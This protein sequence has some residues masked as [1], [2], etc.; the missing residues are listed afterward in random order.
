M[1][2]EMQHSFKH[3]M[4]E[5]KARVGDH[6]LLRKRLAALGAEHVG[7]FHQ[8]DLYFKVPEG[9]LKL[10][11][12]KGTSTVELIYY[13]RENIAGPKSDD[14]FILR[15]KEPGE[16]K[17]ILK[18]TLTPLIVVDKARDIYR[19]NGIQI[20][21]DTVEK[22]GKFIEFEKQTEN[23]PETTEKDRLALQKLMEKLEIDPTNLE[24]LSYSDLIQA[25]K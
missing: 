8:S 11:E 5:L 6:E 4:V 17:K 3:K 19:H 7:T 1:K 14:A 2:I 12:V 16:L 21:L 23:N 9:R 15:V 10:R 13:E 20:H 24:S 25:Q 22:L 18:K